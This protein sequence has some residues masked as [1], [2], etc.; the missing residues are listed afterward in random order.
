MTATATS[1]ASGVAAATETHDYVVVGAGSAGSALAARLSENGKNTVLLLEAGPVDKKMEIH[2]PA[3]FSSLFRSDHD[4]NYD[5]EPQVQ[6]GGR[7]I[8]WPR[9]KMLGGSSSMNAMMWVR[10]FPEDYDA[11]GKAAGP[12]WSWKSL[13]PYFTKVEKVEGASGPETGASGAISV[14]V[15]RSPRSHTAV[16]LNAAKELG[17]KIVDANGK[18]QEGISR[19]LVTQ[20]KGS[21]VSTADGY[22]KPARKRKNLV[23]RTGAQTTRVLFKGTKVVGVEYVTGGV[24][25][26]VHAAKEVI[27]SGGAVNTPQLLLLS[28]IGDRVELQK[29][30]IAVVAH[31]P[32]VGKNLRDHLVSLLAVDTDKDTLFLAQKPGQL[33]SYLSQKK[34]MLTS[35]VAEAYGFIKTDSKLDLP[36]IELIFAPVAF[37]GEGLIGHTDHGLTVGAILLQPESTGTVSLATADPFDKPLIDPNYLSDPN[38]ND[39][40]ALTAGLAVCEELIATKALGAVTKGKFIQPEGAESMSRAERDAL[41]INQYSHT[42]YHPVGTARMGSDASSVVDE[43]LRVR[44]VQGLRVAD[45]SI[46]PGIIR[47][48]TNAPSIVIGEKAAALILR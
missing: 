41:A 3:A 32:E 46:M 2:I 11:W 43:E 35:N 1:A 15:Q 7:R 13:L 34:G 23:V 33:V 38:G 27:L 17:L 42:L 44:G 48:H 36:D 9:G 6:L 31:S 12:G 18:D 10:G 28:G 19:T 29:L 20:A 37:I 8:F 4:W 45:A 21:R 16:F 26:A 14:S 30:G 40:A 24:T 25:K 39:R 22:L 47:G 5:T